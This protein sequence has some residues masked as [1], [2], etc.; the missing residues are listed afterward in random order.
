MLD[1]LACA[2]QKGSDDM[3]KENQVTKN[4]QQVNVLFVQ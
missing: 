2:R 4:Q 3:S 1:L